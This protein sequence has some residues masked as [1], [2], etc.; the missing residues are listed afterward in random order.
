ML[1]HRETPCESPMRAS[2][3]L[4][5]LGHP[6]GQHLVAS[7]DSLGSIGCFRAEPVEHPLQLTL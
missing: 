4:P 5:P 2:S 6:G 1:S 3:D 7:T